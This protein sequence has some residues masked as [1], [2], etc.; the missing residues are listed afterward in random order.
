MKQKTQN[1][2]TWFTILILLITTAN[3]FAQ[4][5]TLTGKV[6]DGRTQEALAGANIIIKELPGRGTS[7][8]T[9]GNYNI[10]L[11]A[12]KYTII[13]SYISY[14]KLEIT[15]VNG[16]YLVSTHSEDDSFDWTDGW[17]GKGQF[18]VAIQDQTAPDADGTANGDCL[19]EADNREDNFA[20]TPQSCPTLANLTLIGNNDNN[21]QKRGIRLRAGT[22]VKMYNILVVGKPNSVTVATAETETSFQNGTSFIEYLWADKG[23]VYE[24]GIADL[25][26]DTKTGNAINQTITFT[27]GYVGTVAGGKDLSADNFF[28]GTNYKGAVPA[29]N[30]WTAGWTRR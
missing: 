9:D 1:V 22:A 23:F 2:K 4:T 19:I 24:G 16:K 13:A 12:G 15:D 14:I 5:G 29:N 10:S 6:S 27:N 7:C 18:W 30:D 17:V 21:N 25:E 28:T 26:L 20:N 3:T 11:P 8:N